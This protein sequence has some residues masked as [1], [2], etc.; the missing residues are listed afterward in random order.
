M[1]SD[2]GSGVGAAEGVGVGV[3]KGVGEGFG[4]GVGEGVGVGVGVAVGAGVGAG[5]GVSEGP[6]EN[7]PWAN[8]PSTITV[9]VNTRQIAGTRIN[10]SFFIRLRRP[11]DAPQNRQK[12]ASLLIFFPHCGHTIFIPPLS[13]YLI[14]YIPANTFLFFDLGKRLRPG[15][16]SFRKGM[17]ILFGKHFFPLWKFVL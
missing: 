16:V 14:P 13:S 17:R 1:D 10:H 3:G 15:F 6:G 9:A 5:E 11:S 4:E 8:G 12:A 7:A 2:A